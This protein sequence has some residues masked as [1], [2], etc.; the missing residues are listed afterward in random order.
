MKRPLFHHHKH[1][2]KLIHHRHTSYPILFALMVVVGGLIFMTDRVATADDLQV[3]ATVPAPIPVGAPVFTT[4]EEGAVFHTPSVD[5]HGTCPVA[6]PAVIISLYESSSLLGSGICQS[7]GTFVI[8]ASLTSG[9]HTIIAS[10]STVTGDN[11]DTSAPLH[12]TYVPSAPPANSG[13]APNPEVTVPR[14]DTITPLDIISEKPYVAFKND[15]NAEWRGRFIGGVSP[16]TLTIM[17]GDGTSDTYNVSSDDLQIF[18]HQYSHNQLYPL[19]VTVRD[20][21]GLQLT[22]H[23]IAMHASGVTDNGE[24]QNTIASLLDNTVVDPYLATIGIYISLLLTTLLLWR[25]E[26]LHYPYRVIGVP[27]H[28]P[29]QKPAPRTARK[30]VH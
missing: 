6:T 17:W 21:S 24:S 14:D 26:H 23:Y 13:S 29:W 4:P 11:G 22:R 8:T 1:T 7:D 18:R 12:I 10:V 15:L 5:F 20:Q 9:A 3:T 25:F 28:Y 16:Y 2:G 19:R 30:K 27:L